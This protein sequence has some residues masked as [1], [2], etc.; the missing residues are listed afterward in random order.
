[1]L[2]Q[3]VSLIVF[4]IFSSDSNP[5]EGALELGYSAACGPKLF[6]RLAR[7]M[8]EDVLEIT[9]A[10]ARRLYSAFESAYEG[11]AAAKKL[12]KMH[13]LAPLSIDNE[14]AE[15]GELIV[16]RVMVDS[17]NAVCPRSGATLRLINLEPDE[18]N[19]TLNTLLKLAE[20]THQSWSG[21]GET[22]DN[23]ALVALREFSDWL[24]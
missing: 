21:R 4:A 13:P 23:H 19:Q 12:V 10:S 5:I 1:M 2:F 22:K 24:K 8:S 15:D 18:R 3:S 17:D 14:P 6:D 11:Q 7:D 16:S 9:S 20:S